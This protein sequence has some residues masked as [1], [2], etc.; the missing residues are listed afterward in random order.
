MDVKI[1]DVSLHPNSWLKEMAK[2]NPV[3]WNISRS[4]RA[5]FA[6][7]FPMVIGYYTNMLMY[8]MWIS[9]GAMFPSI[10]E[11]DA[12]YSFTVR[13]IL[14]SAPIGASGFLMGYLGVI[15]LD[16]VWIVL[17]MS[18][19]GFCLAIA[20]SYSATLSIGCLQF[21]V[22]AAVSLGNPEIGAFWKSSLLLL[23]GACF[24]LVLIFLEK[25]IKPH[26]IRR[27][28]IEQV[29]H[30]LLGICQ[31]K[32]D[33]DDL[34]ESRLQFNLK[35]ENLCNLMLQNRYQAL[36]HNP[37]LD[38]TA[39][40][41]QNLDNIFAA[42]MAQESV[43]EVQRLKEQL[44]GIADAFVQDAAFENI[45]AGG[46]EQWRVLNDLT[47]A[48]WGKSSLS[49][50]AVQSVKKAL[51]VRLML[52]KLA[53]GQATLRSASALALCTAL[54]Y[55]IRWVDHVSHWYWV[56][57][58]VAIVMK[59]EL[60]SIFVRAVQRTVG[61]AAGVMVGG[62]VLTLLPVGPLFI[63]V[64]A[65]ITFV[66]PWLSPRNYALTAF[67]ITP[68]VLVL[69]D[70]LSPGGNGLDYAGLRLVD[71]LMGC[72]IVLL[73]GYLLWPRRH[74]GELEQSMNEARKGIA[75]YLEL[76]LA[77]RLQPAGS[78][79][80]E[81][82][83]AAYGQLVDMRAA[84]QKS[85]AEPPPAGYE[86]AAWFPL[87]AC[88]ARL[89]DAITVYSASASAQPDP[90]EWAWLQQMPQAIA[91]LTDLPVV[92]DAAL[93][94]HSPEAL[95]IT[96]IRKETHVRERLYERVEPDRKQPKSAVVGA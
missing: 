30:A 57:M 26:H 18:V 16:W 33:G 92:P 14:I 66:L 86:A 12:P 63:L 68:L 21:M 78:A 64:I 95:L 17:S 1:K 45:H 31:A 54:G 51:N 75:H 36:G 13:K 96:N 85:M 56:P 49:A 58:T 22:M 94:R 74:G 28:A 81:A 10:G 47:L 5:A 46:S 73:F 62:L 65:V 55:S 19:L 87:V 84:L 32:L 77:H 79:L 48:L 23:C 8:T 7:A 35:Y 38:Q 60:G 20:S 37:A 42:L 15:G 29:F 90:Q 83:R 76:V 39:E 2:I 88:A 43:D 70:F 52:Q 80:N 24:Y 40:V 89:C 71:T 82:R 11:R 3:Q 50:G 91:G 53:P 34:E 44:Q 93:L 27:D 9:M 4:S 67:A 41:V 69:I 61:T 72:A 6:I 59:P 25:W